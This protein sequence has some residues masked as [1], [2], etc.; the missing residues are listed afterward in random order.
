MHASPFPLLKKPVSVLEKDLKADAK[1]LFKALTKA[2]AHVVTGKPAELIGDVGEILASIG[3]KDEPGAVAWVLT[4]R[5][6][7][8]AM[9]SIAFEANLALADALPK[10]EPLSQKADEAL[11]AVE[12]ELNADFFRQPRQIG[13]VEEVQLRRIGV[14]ENVQPLFRDWLVAAGAGEAAAHSAA[15]RLPSYFVFALG[16]EWNSTPAAYT[17]TLT[18]TQHPFA[19]AGVRERAWLRY[20]GH[21]QQ[22]V[23]TGLFGTSFSL[24][25]LYIH[26]RGSYALEPDTAEDRSGETERVQYYLRGGPQKRALVDLRA[27]LNQ[28]VAK[29][30]QDDPVRLIHGGP[31][32]GKS[33]FLKMYAAEQTEQGLRVLYLPLHLL[34]HQ[35]DLIQAV[36]KYLQITKLLSENPLS[37]D[38]SEERLLLLFDGLDELALQGKL[39]GEAANAFAQEVINKLTLLNAKRLRV[40]AVLSGRDVAVQACARAFRG[41]GK[42]LNVEPYLIRAGTF[43]EQKTKDVGDQRADWWKKYGQLSG[44]GYEQVPSELKGNNNLDEITQWPLLNHLVALSYEEGNRDFSNLNRVYQSL[45]GGVYR[46]AYENP[47]RAVSDLKESEF[48]RVLEEIALAAWHGRGRTTTVREIEEHCKRSGLEKLLGKFQSD[49]ENSRVANLLLAFYFRQAGNVS[50]GDAAYEFTHKSFGEYLTVCRIVRGIDRIHKWLKDRDEDVDRGW[51]EKQALEHWVELCGPTAV[52]KYLLSFLRAEVALHPSMWTVWQATLT[53]LLNYLLRHG[54]PMEACNVGSYKK[55]TKQSRNAGEAL[56]AAINACVL[57][58]PSPQLVAVQWPEMAE[59]HHSARSFFDHHQGEGYGVES[60][61]LDCLSYFDYHDCE[62]S[63][64]ILLEADLTGADLTGAKLTGANL[65]GANLLNA[66]LTRVDLLKAN[67]TEA[68]LTGADLTDAYLKR[69]DLT[70]AKLTKANLTKANLT[71]ADLTETDLTE[72]DLTRADLTGA[73]L[74]GADLTGANLDRVFANASTA[75]SRSYSPVN[76]VRKSLPHGHGGYQLLKK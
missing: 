71:E 14:I 25:Q 9:L 50:G 74:T 64:T 10:L 68:D 76:Y 43:T 23:A 75:W 27:A 29:G 35:D 44:R 69:A 40:Q 46:R 5:A 59:R 66:N 32:S 19:E 4:R 55:M 61:F 45:L 65:T 67:L 30:K 52:D 17:E 38:A 2:V 12:V 73:N 70:R 62:L 13:V 57:A 51:N 34:N 6:L 16:E 49:Q 7:E 1:G 31:G 21:L 36:G 53:R 28:W 42:I 72:A 58:N 39:G 22:Q 26:L 3:L 20:N 48:Q 15:E 11:S 56:V 24:R 37:S 63:Y 41:V 8:R 47:H 54:L 60:I 33:S 18:A